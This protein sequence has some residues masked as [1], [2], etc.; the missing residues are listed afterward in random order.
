MEISFNKLSNRNRFSLILRAIKEKQ[1]IPQVFTVKFII[2]AVILCDLLETHRCFAVKNNCRYHLTNRL[3]LF[4]NF[5]N[6]FFKRRHLFHLH[7]ESKQQYKR[8]NKIE[9]DT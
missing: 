3:Q 4:F 1:K 6:L 5:P 7:V 9:T 2:C 8:T